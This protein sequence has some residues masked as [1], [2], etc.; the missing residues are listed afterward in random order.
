MGGVPFQMG[1]KAADFRQ[2]EAFICHMQTLPGEARLF[3]RMGKPVLAKPEVSLLVAVQQLA[4][5][6]APA[7]PMPTE[8]HAAVK[9][10]HPYAVP[11][12]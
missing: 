11:L 9:H 1:L 7:C 2:N 4:A 8:R 6:E 12:V 10:R 5:V 3:R